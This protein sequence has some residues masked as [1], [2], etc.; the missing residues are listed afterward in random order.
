MA[1]VLIADDEASVRDVV[2]RIL[3]IDGHHV[4]EASD[5]EE[6]MRKVRSDHPDLVMMDLFMPRKEGL[7]TI[8]QLRSQFPDIKVIAISGGTPTHGMSF[9]ELA[10]KLGA[11]HTLAKPFGMQAVRDSV[12]ELLETQQAEG[13]MVS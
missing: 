13:H 7:E 2:K 10:K 6:A 1:T 12:S 11:D 4:I 8:R 3:A 5:G 9:L